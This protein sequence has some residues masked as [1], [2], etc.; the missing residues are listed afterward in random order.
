MTVTAVGVVAP[1][2]RLVEALAEREVAPRDRLPLSE[3]V[4]VRD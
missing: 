1:A 4:L 3:L 2:D